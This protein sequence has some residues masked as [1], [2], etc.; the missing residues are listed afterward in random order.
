MGKYPFYVLLE[1]MLSELHKVHS[2]Q[3]AI[4]CRQTNSLL[5]FFFPFFGERRPTSQ[6]PKVQV[7]HL[8]SYCVK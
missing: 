4:I 1:T 7:D 3:R 2:Q 5:S 6:T 8:A